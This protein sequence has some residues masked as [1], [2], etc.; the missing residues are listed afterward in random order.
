[1]VRGERSLPRHRIDGVAVSVGRRYPAHGWPA[2]NS[3]RS[4][5]GCRG[6]CGGGGLPGR[7][8]GC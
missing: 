4:V 2:V 5:A 1:M 3:V 7:K 8:P 6:R